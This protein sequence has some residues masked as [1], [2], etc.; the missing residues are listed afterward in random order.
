M[1]N[2]DPTDKSAEVFFDVTGFRFDDSAF[3][4]YVMA[5][6]DRETLEYIVLKSKTYPDADAAKL[7]YMAVWKY[8]LE[9][10]ELWDPTL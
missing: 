10:R 2:L 7:G 8:L 1:T 6:S 4:L 9:N 5:G 3:T